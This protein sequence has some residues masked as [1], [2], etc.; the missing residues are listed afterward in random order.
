MWPKASVMLMDSELDGQRE[1]VRAKPE[2]HCAFLIAVN[3]CYQNVL[4]ITNISTDMHSKK[5]IQVT[6]EEKKDTRV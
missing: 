1:S 4:L 3:S 2:L 6:R 5:I